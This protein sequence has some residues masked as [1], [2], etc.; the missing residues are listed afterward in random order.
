M[1]TLVKLIVILSLLFPVYASGGCTLK[2]I[3]FKGLDG[4]WDEGAFIDYT[5]IHGACYKIYNWEQVSDAVR[6]IN[7]STT[8]YQLYGFSRGAVS[9]AA[10]LSN[11]GRMPEYV[12]TIGAWHTAN[13]NFSRYGVQYS[14]YFDDSGRY[15]K[16]PGK[17]IPGVPHLKIQ[18]YVNRYYR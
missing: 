15:Q 2:I 7:S 8:P 6:Y 9:V 14:N 18:E 1:S 13:L 12:I 5:N 3:G 10:I 11:V 17:Y 4:I 16:S